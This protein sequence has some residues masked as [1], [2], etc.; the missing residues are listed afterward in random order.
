MKV[1]LIKSLI[2]KDL[3]LQGEKHLSIYSQTCF[4]TCYE[5]ERVFAASLQN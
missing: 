5:Q 2:P 1:F 4:S 3:L